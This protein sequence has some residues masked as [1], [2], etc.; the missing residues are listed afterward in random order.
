V[1]WIGNAEK[2]FYKKIPK[3]E[4]KVRAHG[5]EGTCG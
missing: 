5:K 2:T 1:I 3:E 4:R